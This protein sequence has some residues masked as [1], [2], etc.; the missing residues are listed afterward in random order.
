MLSF[1]GP[2]HSYEDVHYN[3]GENLQGNTSY[4]A[5][6]GP[7]CILNSSFKSFHIGTNY[8]QQSIAPTFRH[9]PLREKCK[10]YISSGKSSA[11]IKRPV[12]IS[13]NSSDSIV[14]PSSDEACREGHMVSVTRREY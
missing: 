8:Q 2:F 4:T 7:K 5:G 3:L 1:G 11:V 6:D 9:Y 10:T 12:T 14:L 13:C